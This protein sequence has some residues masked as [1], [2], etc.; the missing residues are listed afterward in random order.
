MI[1]Q[2][3]WMLVL[4][5]FYCSWIFV[6]QPLM[7]FASLGMAVNSTRMWKF[8]LMAS[9]WMLLKEINLSCFQNTC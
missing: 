1:D 7:I 4:R 2:A 8:Y 9:L 6:L 3:L 5:W